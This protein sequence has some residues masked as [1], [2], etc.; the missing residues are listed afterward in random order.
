M[1]I[2]NKKTNFDIFKHIIAFDILGRILLSEINVNTLEFK[3]TKLGQSNQPILLKIILK[4][5]QVIHKKVIL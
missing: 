4:N 3:T 5:G 1:N 2:K